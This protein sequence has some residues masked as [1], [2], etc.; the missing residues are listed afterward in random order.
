MINLVPRARGGV[1]INDNIIQSKKWFR[2]GG[3][4]KKYFLNWILVAELLY[5]MKRLRDKVN[6]DVFEKY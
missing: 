3:V 6:N 5:F 4:T 1:W 2:S